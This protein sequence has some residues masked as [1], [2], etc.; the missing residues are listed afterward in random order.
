DFRVAGES[1]TLEQLGVIQQYAG[2]DVLRLGDGQWREGGQIVTTGGYYRQAY[3]ELSRNL[4]VK[5]AVGNGL[6]ADIA[7][8]LTYD[9]TTDLL[10][11]NTD[12]EAQVFDEALLDISAS[13][14][15]EEAIAKQWLMLTALVE[16]DPA[17]RADLSDAIGRFVSTYSGDVE[18]LLPAF[19]NPV[20]EYLDIDSNIGSSGADTIYGGETED[21]IVGFG[22]ND[23]LYGRAGDDAL[24]GNDGNDYL[25]GEA[26][27]DV[28]DG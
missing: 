8:G 7:P 14:G 3:I 18:S 21:V 28:L 23:R 9:A 2:M 12:I 15:D 16:I 27:N 24:Y 10:T 11:T 1:F 25:Y 19:E 22:G 13:L 6:L 4:L 26:G 5:F 17:A 20:F